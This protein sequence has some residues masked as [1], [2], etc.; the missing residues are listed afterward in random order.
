MGCSVL[1]GQ[2]SRF[3]MAAVKQ[4]TE[5][6]EEMRQKDVRV[7]ERQMKWSRKE[8]GDIP[9]KPQGAGTTQDHLRSPLRPHLHSYQTP[10]A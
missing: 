2:R 6:N 1:G 7:G 10:V 8:I 9:S 3:G 5:G 4:R